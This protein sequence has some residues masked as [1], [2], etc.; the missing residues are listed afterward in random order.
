MRILTGDIGG[1]KTLLRITDIG[2]HPS[3]VRY[4]KRYLSE[5]FPSLE[6]MVQQFLAEAGGMHIDS[7]CFAVAGP[8]RRVD[9]A[10][11]SRITNLPWVLDSAALATRCGLPR[12]QL[13]N[14]FEAVGY[15]IDEL[16]PE[17]VVALRPGAAD[18][19]RPRLV[20]GAGTGLGVCQLVPSPQGTQVFPSE[21]GHMDFAPTSE[22]QQEFLRFMWKR[23]N[24]RISYDRIVSGPGLAALFEF[25]VERESAGDY[26]R[27][28]DILVADD[29]PSAVSASQAE[30]PIARRAVDMFLEIYGAQAGNLALVTL[31]T[32]GVYI[33]GGIAPKLIK[34]LQKGGFVEGFLSK[35]RLRPVL[36]NMPLQVV[37]RPDVGLLGAAAL[38]RQ[39]AK[40]SV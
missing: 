8:V 5:D 37:M 13:V 19:S 11:H 15:G 2:L 27:V 6:P 26:A 16:G 22:L 29:V 4:E 36:E 3:R 9:Q 28:R 17:E 1:T 35:G 25:L 20:L 34:E 39:A 10:A 14:D 40:L 31:A 33:G 38:A 21:G 18:R 32:G 24:S 23:H 12:V 30:V 7:A